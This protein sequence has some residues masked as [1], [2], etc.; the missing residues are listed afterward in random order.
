M[1]TKREADYDEHISP[2]ME[3]IIALCKEHKIP[4]IASFDIS[5]ED[6]E[7]DGADTLRCTT[8]VHGADWPADPTFIKALSVLKPPAPSFMAFTITTVPKP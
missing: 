7:Q 4:L 3:K 2:L 5:G 6:D 1:S 8:C